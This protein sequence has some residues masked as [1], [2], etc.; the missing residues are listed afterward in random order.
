MIR[1]IKPII[2]LNAGITAVYDTYMGLYKMKP[3]KN[4]KENVQLINGILT[5]KSGDTYVIKY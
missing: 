3:C 4:R 2:E 1:M 5:L